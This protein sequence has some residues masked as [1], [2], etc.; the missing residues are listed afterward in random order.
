MKEKT[1]IEIIYPDNTK[2]LV[3]EVTYL[4]SSDDRFQYLVFSKGEIQG[5]A[6][7]EVIYISKLLIVN[8]EYKIE[9][10]EED[11]EW[12]EVLQLLKEIANKKESEQG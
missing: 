10:I 5:E 4:N 8:N 6:R 7:E 2:E 12:K 1:M 9:E 11:V 3:E